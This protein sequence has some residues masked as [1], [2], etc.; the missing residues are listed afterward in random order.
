MQN[1]KLNKQM[2]KNINDKI[3]NDVNINSSITFKNQ[4]NENGIKSNQMELTPEQKK[5]QE[6]NRRKEQEKKRELM[7]KIKNLTFEPF[8]KEKNTSFENSMVKKAD[9]RSPIKHLSEAGIRKNI[10]LKLQKEQ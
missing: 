8:N 10:E 6:E 7:E 5:Q 9:G 1:S 4:S 3:N 2:I